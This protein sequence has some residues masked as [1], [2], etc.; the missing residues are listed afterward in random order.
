M[1]FFAQTAGE[2]QENFM[3]AL[4]VLFGGWRGHLVN[5]EFALYNSGQK[6]I[7]RICNRP[8]HLQLHCIQKQYFLRIADDAEPLFDAKHLF[9]GRL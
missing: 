9:I 7:K 5:G 1:S 3:N 4:F 6:S 2:G 8:S